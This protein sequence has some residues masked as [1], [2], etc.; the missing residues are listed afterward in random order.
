MWKLTQ[1]LLGVVVVA[2]PGIIEINKDASFKVHG[3]EG[4]FLESGSYMVRKDGKTYTTAD[5]SLG[6][7][8]TAVSSGLDNMG[9]FHKYS[10]SMTPEKS[11]EPV[12]EARI[13]VY[14]RQNVAIFTQDF[15]KGVKGMSLKSRTKVTS[16]FPSVKVPSKSDSFYLNPCD[17]MGG[18]EQLK[19]GPWQQS[20]MNN[21]CKGDPRKS[22]HKLITV[23]SQNCVSQKSA[24]FRFWPYKKIGGYTVSH[25]IY[26]H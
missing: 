15:P 17:D 2:V 20:G 25:Q 1:L 19:K 8:Q 13:K 7:K 9:E 22:V 14:G 11:D 12:M 23:C 16:S 24:V 10:F 18:W 5:G 6:V 4:F 3:T 21:M 26:V